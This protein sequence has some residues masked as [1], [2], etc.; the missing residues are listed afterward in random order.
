MPRIPG[1]ATGELRR[2]QRSAP[3]QD[4]NLPVFEPAAAK[5]APRKRWASTFGELRAV[6]G[7]FAEA[8]VAETRWCAIIAWLGRE[9]NLAAL[10]NSPEISMHVARFSQEHDRES[11]GLPTRGRMPH[12]SPFPQM[13]EELRQYVRE[14]AGELIADWERAD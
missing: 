12:K 4:R 8:I 2:L 13:S 1:L 14:R 7:R 3:P 11:L 10:T 6:A 9:W 5:A